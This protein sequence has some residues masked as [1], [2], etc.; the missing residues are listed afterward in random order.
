VG[1]LHYLLPSAA[2]CRSRGR[3]SSRLALTLLPQSLQ[4]EARALEAAKQRVVQ[5]VEAFMAF[6]NVSTCV[7]FA[8]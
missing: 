7:R 4:L 2:A 6:K 8:L 1:C 5:L 3:V